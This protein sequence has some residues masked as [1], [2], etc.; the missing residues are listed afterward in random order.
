MYWSD[1]YGLSSIVVKLQ[2]VVG[3]TYRYDVLLST[4]CCIEKKLGLLRIK[5]IYE[6]NT[7]KN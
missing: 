3:V 4:Y 6:T 5:E 2:V 1:Y 7:R